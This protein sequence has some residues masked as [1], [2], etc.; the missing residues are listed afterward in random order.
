MTID[1]NGALLAGESR[2]PVEGAAIYRVDPLTGERQLVS[3][4]GTGVGEALNGSTF[5]TLAGAT[6]LIVDPRNPAK[7]LVSGESLLSL[8]VATGDWFE[9]AGDLGEFSQVFA[10]LGGIDVTRDGRF[11]ILGDDG[12]LFTFDRDTSQLASLVLVGDSSQPDVIPL[13][14]A[15]TPG[16]TSA[17]ANSGDSLAR[18]DLVTGTREIISG[19]GIGTGPQFESLVLMHVIVPEP[20]GTFL[21]VSALPLIVVMRWFRK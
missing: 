2:D 13:D 15:F 11:V 10:A 17:Y 14:L 16:Q 1:Q 20:T 18:V 21:V 12:V 8:D 7:L 9:L 6:E 5:D 19:V 4:L 3:G